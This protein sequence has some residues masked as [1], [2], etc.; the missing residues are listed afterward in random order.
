MSQ[1]HTVQ[2]ATGVIA[3]DENGDILIAAGKDKPAAG[4]KGYA[5]GCIF[6]DTDSGTVHVN[7]DTDADG[8]AAFGSAIS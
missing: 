2:D 1:R 4:A 7:A 5:P 6:I 3:V 8:S